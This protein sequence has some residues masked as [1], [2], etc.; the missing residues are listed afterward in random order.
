VDREH[1][2]QHDIDNLL[3][4][5][6][7]Q[8][9]TAARSHLEGCADCRAA[10]DRGRHVVL[11]IEQL[12]YRAPSL[13]FSSVV[14]ARVTIHEP[15]HVSIVDAIQRLAPRSPGLR[16]ALGGAAAMIGLLVTSALVWMGT[17]AT[18]LQFVANITI[19]RV[20]SAALS[21]AEDATV[22]IVGEPTLAM[23]GLQGVRGIWFTLW[24]LCSCAFVA[25][26]GLR[27]LANA[28]RRRVP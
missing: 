18:A 17:R 1:L 6:Q 5:E 20:A 23:L 21:G 27:L 16:V 7:G 11:L 10:Y 15:F 19:E 9:Q 25:A 2:T 24:L 14:M 28:A 22:A 13:G 3:D 8:E 26:F 4:Q 12:P